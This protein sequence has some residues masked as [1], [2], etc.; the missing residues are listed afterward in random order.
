MDK[1]SSRE[2]NVPSF[3]CE[4][5]REKLGG[6]AFGSSD[7][8]NLDCLVSFYCK[9]VA[10]KNVGS[11]VM[12][13]SVTDLRF[14]MQRSDGSQRCYSFGRW[15]FKLLARIYLVLCCWYCTHPLGK[16]IF[17]PRYRSSPVLGG[18]SQASEAPRPLG[19]SRTWVLAQNSN[20]LQVQRFFL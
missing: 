9:Q 17:L 3:S 6:E 12:S 13:R 1:L 10:E 2:M 7:E 5:F 14:V 8:D 15:G 4:L 20:F 19:A 11:L 16:G 18:G